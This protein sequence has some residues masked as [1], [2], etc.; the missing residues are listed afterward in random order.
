MVAANRGAIKITSD[1]TRS[2]DKSEKDSFLAVSFQNTNQILS[3]K[4]NLIIEKRKFFNWSL[5]IDLSTCASPQEGNCAFDLLP[6]LQNKLQAGPLQNRQTRDQDCGCRLRWDCDG[7]EWLHDCCS[8]INW[9]TAE[10]S[11]APALRSLGN[12]RGYLCKQSWCWYL[13]WATQIWLPRHHSIKQRFIYDQTFISVNFFQWK[14][15][16]ML[17]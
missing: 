16:A 13:L 2:L 12:S 17:F 10:Q 7:L 15:T 9:L 11:R 4:N 3:S 5:I 6:A 8:H 14:Q 1:K